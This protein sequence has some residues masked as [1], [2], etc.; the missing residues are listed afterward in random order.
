MAFLRQGALHLQPTYF[1]YS[2]HMPLCTLSNYMH[3]QLHMTCMTSLFPPPLTSFPFPWLLSQT[4]W[5]NTLA[6]STSSVYSSFTLAV[7]TPSSAC[8]SHRHNRIHRRHFVIFQSRKSWLEH[9]L[10]LPHI[11]H[12]M[13]DL[14]ILFFIWVNNNICLQWRG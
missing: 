6:P 2:S 12:G 14:V 4:K 3:W 1:H 11:L 10:S 7:R 8:Y 9:G 5:L 13:Q